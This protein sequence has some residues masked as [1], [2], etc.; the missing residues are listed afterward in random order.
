M[1]EYNG[2]NQ[3]RRVPADAIVKD[4][5][6]LEYH[7]PAVKTGSMDARK[8]AANITA[9]SD[10]LDVISESA[11]GEKA[12]LRTD[13]QGFRGDSFDIDFVYQLGGVAATLWSAAPTT[14]KDVLDLIKDSFDLW[15]HLRAEPPKA[16]VHAED[17]AQLINV[18]NNSGQILAVNHAVFNVVSNPRAGTA[19]AAF[20]G[21]TVNA[22]GIEDVRIHSEAANDESLVTRDDAYCFIPVD[23]KR[24][25][26]ET[27]LETWVIIESPNFKEGNKWRVSDGQTSFNVSMDD[28]EF[29]QAIDEG[30]QRFGKG[31]MMRVN[32]LI[33]QSSSLGRLSSERSILKVLE[34]KRGSEQQRMFED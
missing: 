6:S 10:F 2:G 34:H 22:N 9:F 33:K 31:D 3:R 19:V 4:R 12:Q 23:V 7:G 28:A 29:L 24:P 21:D 1:A 32:M 30:A 17:D 16:A 18:E 5:L 14:P 27:E 11:Y 13:V 25:L 8:V 26:S 15:K 20:I